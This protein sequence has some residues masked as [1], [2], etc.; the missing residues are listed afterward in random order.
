MCRGAPCTSDQS[1]KNARISFLGI[2]VGTTMVPSLLC[3]ISLFRP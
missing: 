3:R 2:Y 1:N